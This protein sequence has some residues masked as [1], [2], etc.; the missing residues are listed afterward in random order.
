MPIS[1][2]VR[3]FL[4][5]AVP[6]SRHRRTPRALVE[7]GRAGPLSATLSHSGDHV[8]RTVTLEI[9]GLPCRMTTDADE[10][11]LRYLATLINERI[12][13]LGPRA[14]K[15][16]IP[17]QLLA[18]VALGLAEELTESEGKRRELVKRTELALQHAIARLDDRLRNTNQ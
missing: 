12:A 10:D 4:I 1:A 13:A 2:I 17:A 15:T 8:K 9:A 14:Q 3:R 5:L 18:I 6:L 11:H 7:K 16:T